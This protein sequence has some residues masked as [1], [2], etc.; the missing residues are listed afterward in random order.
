MRASKHNKEKR[1]DAIP[2]WIVHG[3]A[4]RV[5]KSPTQ[6]KG[7]LSGLDSFAC[8]RTATS[9]NIWLGSVA[10]GS[11]ATFGLGDVPALICRE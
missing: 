8:D 6:A 4:D 10:A 11:E 9:S 1:N 3:R 7:S 2:Q 5:E